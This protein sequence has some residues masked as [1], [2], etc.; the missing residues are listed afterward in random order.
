MVLEVG[1]RVKFAG[2]KQRFT[3]QAASERFA[4][5]TK[6]FNPRRSVIYTIV[7]FEQGIRGTENLIFCA[8]FE[9][10]EDCLEALARLEAGETQVSRRN[11]VSLEIDQ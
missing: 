3:V 2:E 11:W 8:G 6:P 10:R 1:S 4:V 5:C 9:T 7:D